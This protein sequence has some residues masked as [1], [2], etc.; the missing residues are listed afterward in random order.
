MFSV[1]RFTGRRAPAVQVIFDTLCVKASKNLRGGAGRA[2]LASTI[3]LRG[4]KSEGRKP[5]LEGRPKAEIRNNA[6]PDRLLACQPG[7]RFGLR[8]SDFSRISGFGLRIWRAHDGWQCSDAPGRWPGHHCRQGWPERYSACRA[9][10]CS[11]RLDWFV[12]VASAKARSLVATAWAK[13]P[14]SA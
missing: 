4:L 6:F 10:I 7:G 9:R 11:R 13:S 8:N 14:A 2:L 3:S 1:E 5:K 12:A